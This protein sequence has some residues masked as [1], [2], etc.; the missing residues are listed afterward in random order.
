M[1]DAT[2]PDKPRRLVVNLPGREYRKVREAADEFGVTMTEVVRQ[3]LRVRGIVVEKQQ[4]GKQLAFVDADGKIL[5][6]FL[7][8]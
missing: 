7:V 8:I 4:E 3:A 6:R 5:G 2:D 1:A